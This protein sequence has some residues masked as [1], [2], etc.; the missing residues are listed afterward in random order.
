MNRT[1]LPLRSMQKK[2]ALLCSLVLSACAPGSPPAVQPSSAVGS[3][4][5]FRDIETARI[6]DGRL[7]L[8]AF[9]SA[10][11][12]AFV[13]PRPGRVQTG[14]GPS[15]EDSVTNRL[16][17]V[18]VTSPAYLDA[19]GRQR[20]G[21]ELLNTQTAYLKRIGIAASLTLVGL[22]DTEGVVRE[23][24]IAR[25]S[26]YHDLDTS[27]AQVLRRTRF[28]PAMAGECRVPYVIRLPISLT[29]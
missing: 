4:R 11:R 13:G 27:V 20:F 24:R 15:P 12:V 2:I 17:G 22:I 23:T 18:L 29:P 7:L 16:L 10:A 28:E 9:D 19:A 26:G 6:P 21:R 3:C 8:E 1:P 25:G 5:D 14:R